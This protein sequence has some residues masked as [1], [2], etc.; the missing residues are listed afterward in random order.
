[1]LFLT[2]SKLLTCLSIGLPEKIIFFP[3]VPNGKLMVLGV[4]VF[5]DIMLHNNLFI[6]RCSEAGW[7]DS[8]PY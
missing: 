8:H 6:C 3:F 2:I 5:K 4:P 1:M 7:G